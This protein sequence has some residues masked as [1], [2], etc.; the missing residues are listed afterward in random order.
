MNANDQIYVCPR[1]H[2][3]LRLEIEKSDGPRVVSG[4]LHAPD[5]ERYRIDEGIPDL[6]YPPTLHETDKRAR[7]F[8]DMRADVY[9][10]YLHLT[11]ETFWENEET[12]R[13]KMIDT[14]ALKP[15]HRVL[16]VSC[17]TGRDS[18]L[19]AER[20]SAEGQLYLQ[21]LS[22]PMLE[23]CIDRLGHTDVPVE[24]CVSNAC[25][26]PFPD[27]FFD[28][29]Y[30]FGGL[31]EFSDIG[32][33]LAEMAR[34]TKVG[35]LVVAGDESMPPWLRGTRFAKILTTTNPQFE[36]ELPLK[37][38][39]VVAREFRLRWIIG[40]VF[41][42]MDFVVGEGEPPANFDYEIPG[43]RGGTHTTRHYGQL[44]GVKLETKRLAQEACAQ[45][46]K[47]MH[48]WLDEVV[49]LAAAQQLKDKS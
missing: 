41:Y 4:C 21:D 42:L 12:T 16:E 2:S 15:N 24:M 38:V 32:R 20:L 45:S 18:K 11:F 39:P 37:Y 10:K 14:L 22:H 47:S 9:D 6:T 31:G 5:G 17:G 29:V 3:K 34:V 49:G 26:L 19:I 36:A 7:D 48:A 46:G 35:G 8:Y 30:H 40:G 1:T 44:E 28:A 43:P 23:R 33:A 25:Y 13:N 27:R